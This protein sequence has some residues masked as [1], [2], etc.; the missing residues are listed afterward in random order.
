MNSLPEPRSGK[1]NL[2]RNRSAD[3]AAR[4]EIILIFSLNC[5]D[6]SNGKDIFREKLELPDHFA[7]RKKIILIFSLNCDDR[8]NRKD[9][10]H[11]ILELLDPVR[12]ASPYA[13][14]SNASQSY[15]HGVNL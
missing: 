7:A 3:F 5:D 15:F 8:S 12:G 4:K 6:R 14:I 2:Y 11:E 10:S 9:I 13:T 1:L